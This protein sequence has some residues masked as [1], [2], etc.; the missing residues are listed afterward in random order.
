[1]L[2]ASCFISFTS[3]V[4]LFIPF[5]MPQAFAVGAYVD[6][7]KDA[8]NSFVNAK[9]KL[10]DCVNDLVRPEFTAGAAAEPACL[11]PL[12]EANAKAL[13][14]HECRSKSHTGSW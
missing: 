9:E 12:R 11:K 10:E 1:V 14:L 4:L 6:P 7:C 8:E 3:V 2:R 13:Q 5:Q